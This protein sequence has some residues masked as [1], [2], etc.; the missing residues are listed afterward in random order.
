MSPMLEHEDLNVRQ[1]AAV[2]W[3]E[4]ERS[5][6]ATNEVARLLSDDDPIIRSAG[7]F[8]IEEEDVVHSDWLEALVPGLLEKGPEAV[9][10]AV[11]H[12][13]RDHA[14]ARE[15][16]LRFAQRELEVHPASEIAFAFRARDRVVDGPA[17]RH[18]HPFA[19]SIET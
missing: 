15:I 14:G 13:L 12:W 6:A 10:E 8:A 4:T 1:W 11:A 16:S 9:V 5:E 7:G 3:A 17:T 18:Q 19:A 2:L